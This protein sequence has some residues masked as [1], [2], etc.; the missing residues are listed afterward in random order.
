MSEL[1]LCNNTIASLPYYVENMSLN[2]YS[3]EELAYYILN[4]I[5]VIDKSFM[6][7][8]LCGWIE[9]ELKMTKLGEQ[10]RDI[11]SSKGLL[12]T[13]LQC[14]LQ[15][16]GYCSRDQ[17][18]E[19]LFVIR[20]LEEKSEFECSKLRADRLMEK[21]KY[22]ASIYE[23][24]RLLDLEDAKEENP[25]LIGNIWH[26]LGVA[27]ARL[28]LFEEAVNCFKQAYKNNRKM[29]SMKECLFAYRCMRDELGFSRYANENNLDEDLKTAIKNELTSASRNDHTKIFEETLEQIAHLNDHGNRMEYQK[30]ISDIILSWKEDY[31]KS[32]KV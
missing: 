9:Q 16:S 4:D 29:E 18:E 11:M 15:E 23:Y 19:V 3:I 1:L 2:L 5:Y 12:S 31:R 27:Y 14:I 22:I 30:A 17:M 32:C 21:E 7:Q 20:E 25:V 6:S 24:K 10:L 8:E 28:Y 13:Y 26:N